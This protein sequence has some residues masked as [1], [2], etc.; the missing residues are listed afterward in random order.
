VRIEVDGAEHL[1]REMLEVVR[2]SGRPGDGREGEFEE[3]DLAR[4]PDA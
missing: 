2:D 3:P 4:P 1:Q